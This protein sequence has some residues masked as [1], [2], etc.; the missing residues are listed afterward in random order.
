MSGARLLFGTEEPPPRRDMLTA[1]RLSAV[2]EAGGLRHL[3]WDGL[4]V[5]RAVAF[6]IRDTSWG[7]YRADLADLQI[8]AD[9][10]RFD[11]AFK[12]NCD[13]PEGDLRFAA[14]IE[15]SSSGR[16]T[17]RAQGSSERGFCTNRTGFV[18]LH[19]LA[20]T[21][22]RPVRVEHVGGGRSD[23]MFPDCVAPAQPI[24][25]IRALTHQPRD[26][27]SV[28]VRM[29]GDTFEM[30]DQRNWTDAS[31]K[32][33]VRP[34]ERGFPY[35]IAPGETVEQSVEVVI[36]DTIAATV[37]RRAD[38]RRATVGIPVGTVP[39]VG[40]AIAPEDLP[41]LA[42]PASPRPTYIVARADL[43]GPPALELQR[44]AEVCGRRGIA[45]DVD[46]IADGPTAIDAFARTLRDA[47]LLP[48]RLLVMSQDGATAGELRLA[49]RGAFPGVPIGGGTVFGFADLNRNRPPKGI[50][51]VA[52][53][54]Q[55]IVH[56]ADD[57]SVMETLEALPDVIRT[58]QAFAPCADYRIGPGTIG[59][60]AAFYA[61]RCGPNPERRRV[62]A[63]ESDP[64]QDGLFAAAFALGYFAVAAEAG[65]AAVTLGTCT[66]PA[67]VCGPDGPRPVAAVVAAAAALAGAPRPS[68]EITGQGFCALAATTG[69]G[70]DL[71][72]ANLTNA[73]IRVAVA[74]AQFR[75]ACRIDVGT[76]G[77][78][79][80]NAPWAGGAVDLDAYGICGL[81]EA[82]DEQ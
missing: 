67:G 73:P 75:F 58:A 46:V 68:V 72:L 32:T 79:G 21:V 52:H 33:Y 10:E 44:L 16:L 39:Q 2:L 23:G 8:E 18:V 70:V 1:G 57:I 11:V 25:D 29:A 77:I 53:S 28:Q 24:R 65:V 71:W 9:A 74:G 27:L 59:A 69:R 22:G 13:G 66:G 38:V 56:A 14:R 51:F 82:R 26:G 34:L 49:A 36:E 60:P 55:A 61:S 42:D 50:D 80:A 12:A 63:A 6:V 48:R 81:S 35:V 7:T 62:P 20:G 15:G 64:R 37:V 45:V 5:L 3:R 41:V 30:E 17:F 76:R 78:L 4:E 43:S 19:D 31:F 54:T 40:L 47:E